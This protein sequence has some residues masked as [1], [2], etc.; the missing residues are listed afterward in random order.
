MKVT[1]NERIVQ[2][3]GKIAQQV[4]LVGLAM[5]AGATFLSF[6][7]NRLLLAYAIVVPGIVLSSWAMRAADKWLRTPR[8]DQLLAKSLKGLTQGYRQ[9]SYLQP[10]D[11]V[12]LSPSQVF[13]VRVK[14]QDGQISCLSDK[15]HR[16]FS[17]RRLMG[18]MGEEPLGNPTAQALADAR[19][20]DSY[21]A[22]H[23]PDAH[24][25]V[26]PVVVFLN[27]KAELE[28]SA[29]GVPVVRLE[30][31]KSFLRGNEGTPPLPEQARESLFALFDEQVS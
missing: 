17:F 3:K 16:P 24:V 23:L 30:N 6:S 20:L 7:Q 8:A 13:A 2:R 5:L 10:V 22:K 14:R 21:L 15:W 28:I 25:P 12:I 11:H 9:Y 18:F 19:K 27:T 1:V 31:L 4:V 29:C 26:Q